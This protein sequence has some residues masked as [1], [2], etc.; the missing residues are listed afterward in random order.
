MR[1]GEPSFL[2]NVHK[3]LILGNLI[4]LLQKSIAANAR[5]KED[6]EPM[7]FHT[8]LKLSKE[9]RKD[10]IARLLM[11]ILE[12]YYEED[13]LPAKIKEYDSDLQESITSPL[14]HAQSE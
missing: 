11:P 9:M 1:R 10:H 6:A 4:L 7:I 14:R 5:F 12:A 13:G 3:Y 2:R 8:Y